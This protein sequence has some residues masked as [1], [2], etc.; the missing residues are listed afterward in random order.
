M[1]FGED[2]TKAKNGEM[3]FSNVLLEG[4]W[5]VQLFKGFEN[6]K[7]N[8]EPMFFERQGVQW[9]VL[10]MERWRWVDSWGLMA[11][12]PALFGEF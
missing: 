11:S 2:T 1:G 8:P 6:P 7:W 3:T 10:V 12:Q 9:C 4:G 5:M